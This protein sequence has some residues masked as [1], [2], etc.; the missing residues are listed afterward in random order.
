M[1][2]RGEIRAEMARYN[3]TEKDMAEKLNIAINTFRNKM[4]SKTDFTETDIQGLCIIFN[5]PCSFF[6]NVEWL[7]NDHLQP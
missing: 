5:K 2:N 1:I 3:L 4:Q 7:K 6:F